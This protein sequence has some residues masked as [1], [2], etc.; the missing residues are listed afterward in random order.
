MIRKIGFR[1]AVPAS[2]EHKIQ[3]GRRS[4]QEMSNVHRRK[5][6]K[7]WS[8]N[9]AWMPGRLKAASLGSALTSF[10]CSNAA[11]WAMAGSLPWDEM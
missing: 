3:G 9:P 11:R 5:Q 6:Q 7:G 2:E 4:V 8:L 10:P 1:I